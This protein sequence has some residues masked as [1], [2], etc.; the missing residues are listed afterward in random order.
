M[1]DSVSIDQRSSQRAFPGRLSAI[2][3]PRVLLVD[4]SPENALRA[5][6]RVVWT[7]ARTR[8]SPGVRGKAPGSSP[9][10]RPAHLARALPVSVGRP[11]PDAAG[12][13]KGLPQGRA[14]RALDGTSYTPD[15]TDGGRPT[16][17]GLD[18][19]WRTR[20]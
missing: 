18:L 20:L 10:V 13:V 4:R 17:P 12:A 6:N 5:A 19:G 3:V 9:D 14:Q 8:G 1:D 15:A 2:E 7:Y 16:P 11:P